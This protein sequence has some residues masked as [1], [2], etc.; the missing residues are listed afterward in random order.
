MKKEL[1]PKVVIITGASSGIGKATALMLKNE[2]HIV[3][4]VARRVE[5]MKDLETAGIK[6]IKTDLTIDKDMTNLVETVVKENGR[7]DVLVNNAGY[8]DYG[9]IEDVSMETARKQIEVNLIG[10]ARMCQLVLPH[11]RAQKSGKIFNIS[12]I[13]GK[14]STP[15][16]GWYH[17][18]K[19]AVE[20][21]SNSLRLETKK[22]CIDVI[23]V[24]PG[25]IAT[26]WSSVMLDN[27]KKTSG[28]GAYKED[29]EKFTAFFS[30]IEHRGGKETASSPDVIAKVI[31]KGM[32]AKNPKIRYVAGKLAKPI[33]FMRKILSDKAFD[34]LIL[35]MFN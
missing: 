31:S 23:V 7:I 20:G 17:A 10:L 34:K 9:A 27:L 30:H 16:G 6:I 35:K 12:S 5:M 15:L 4:G 33:L 13:G 1:T 14:I 21:L 22:F 26:E 19:F 11:M 18:S 24:E 2:G 32:K 3:Y 8:G 25:A 28:N 29:V